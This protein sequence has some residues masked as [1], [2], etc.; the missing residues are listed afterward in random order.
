M[1]REPA[2]QS[3]GLTASALCEHYVRIRNL[4]SYYDWM[5]DMFDQRDLLYCTALQILGLATRR[6]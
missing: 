6:Y 2:K 4:K 1:Y 5:V 3:T